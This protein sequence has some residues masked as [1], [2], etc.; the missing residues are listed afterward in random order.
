VTR[1]RGAAER[2]LIQAVRR[3]K[4]VVGCRPA[5]LSELIWWLAA[6]VPGG[7]FVP[8]WAE[9][10][11]V[12]AAL[13]EERGPLG[14]PA[15]R[16][17]GLA[18][19]TAAVRI[20]RGLGPGRFW[21]GARE[22]FPQPDS[23]SERE[24]LARVTAACER[25]LDRH[26]LIDAV[27]AARLAAAGEPP[28]S[29]GEL[30]LV[31][32]EPPA[33]L[34]REL[35]ERLAEQVSA[36]WLQPDPGEEEAPAVE[37]RELEASH[38]A[39]AVCRRAAADLRRALDAGAGAEQMAVAI[40]GGAGARRRAAALL[41][42]FGA[43]VHGDSAP[44][45]EVFE[46]IAALITGRA[47]REQVARLLAAGR[48]SGTDSFTAVEAGG[49]AA[50]AGCAGSSADEWWARLQAHAR[51][52]EREAS[53][54]GGRGRAPNWPGAG[55]G[56]ERER[57]ARARVLAHAAGD[58]LHRAHR[59]RERM[60][61]RGA[62][63]TWSR[64]G[65][66]LRAFAAPLL[67]SGET[68]WRASRA[69]DALAALDHFRLRVS[70]ELATGLWLD[71]ARKAHR[72]AAG[73]EPSAGPSLV[74]EQDLVEHCPAIAWW[75]E[76]PD[77]DPGSLASPGPLDVP[78]PPRV[79]TPG[80][81]PGD[82]A[83]RCGASVVT[84]V[85]SA[86]RDAPEAPPSAGSS[87][88]QSPWTR[89]AI[90]ARRM[91]AQE[92]RRDASEPDAHS[93]SIG[94]AGDRM[95]RLTLVDLGELSRCPFRFLV[96]RLLGVPGDR[97][98][99]GTPALEPS[100]AEVFAVR[101]HA[102]ADAWSILEDGA[103]PA[104]PV[105]D[106]RIADRAIRWCRL[107]IEEARG[108]GARGAPARWTELAESMERELART[109]HRELHRMRRLRL[110]TVATPR[111]RVVAVERAGHALEI[112]VRIDRLDRVSNG[113]NLATIWV[114]PAR[115]APCWWEQALTAA[116]AQQA[117]AA[118]DGSSRLSVRFAS[119]APAG[120]SSTTGL[121]TESGLRRVQARLDQ[122]VSALARRVAEGELFPAPDGPAV[123]EGC[124]YR[125]LC[126]RH[127]RELH[128]LKA[129]APA[130]RDHLAALGR[131]P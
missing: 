127:E 46:A 25:H 51:G 74:S 64:V 79:A 109:V 31:L 59:I 28:A 89:P 33:P 58:L 54:G 96:G 116:A 39:A 21:E 85:V 20:S 65:E 115:P 93:G 23:P 18:W 66:E 19:L 22:D 3:R 88:P 120:R 1:S 98:G 122:V 15:R 38:S 50:E 102:L 37:V 30:L 70:V 16:A 103:P 62:A 68:A 40:A 48:R 108:G 106:E 12:H 123:C 34:E 77:A 128:R 104:D 41:E 26:G 63:A 99:E 130:V 60:R 129:A 117:R 73:V 113:G 4:L 83:L 8:E 52:L 53:R 105:E 72:P 10:A 92:S 24:H 124:P 75:L 112:S 118:E 126:T 45:E 49:L 17:G 78:D 90:V 101:R 36:I 14:R 6:A 76:L 67:G 125:R 110:T 35:I 47:T 5:S 119:L 32:S 56:S 81:R 95:P 94:P 97:P 7:R 11:L 84:R 13:R 71:R 9:P 29:A 100:P 82:R 107:R 114:D 87:P 44:P 91:R 55:P 111:P 42:R 80:R 86:P 43:P 2:L 69:A 61:R 57:A 121:W 27:R 131:L